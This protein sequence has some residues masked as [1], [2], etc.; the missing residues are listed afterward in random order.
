[1]RPMRKVAIP[2]TSKVAI[3]VALRP[4][5][6]PYVPKSQAPSGRARN[7]TKKIA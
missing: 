6:S 7:P 5:R 4:M 2:M 1:M 3:S